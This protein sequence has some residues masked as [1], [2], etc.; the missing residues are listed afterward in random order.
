[1]D[2]P[3]FKTLVHCEGQELEISA[4]SWLQLRY[5]LNYIARMGSGPKGF[6]VYGERERTGFSKGEEIW[7][8][9]TDGL[10]HWWQ[11]ERSPQG[12]S[13][14]IVAIELNDTWFMIPKSDLQGAQKFPNPMRAETP[15]RLHVPIDELRCR[16]VDVPVDPMIRKG[17][18]PSSVWLVE[19]EPLDWKGPVTIQVRVNDD[20]HRR[21]IMR[22]QTQLQLEDRLDNMPGRDE[23]TIWFSPDR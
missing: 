9:W 5:R 18:L 14:K 23:E 3:E 2:W 15:E 6:R 11:W 22:G 7:V 4:G 1:M 13:Q 16:K 17:V 12:I 20:I 19:F 21:Q 10:L 8:Y